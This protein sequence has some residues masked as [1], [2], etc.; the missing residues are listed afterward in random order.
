[1]NN[2]YY[3][4]APFAGL[5]S[6]AAHDFVINFMSNRSEA[7]PGG[8]LNRD[9]LKSFFAVTGEPGSFVHNRG[10]ERIPDVSIDLDIEVSSSYLHLLQNW[11]KRPSLN[12]YNIP[13][14]LA[15]VFV[16]N[17][18]YVSPY[19]EDQV[20]NHTYTNGSRKGTPELLDLVETRVRSTA[21]LASMS[22][23]SLEAS[24]TLPILLRA[25]TV[26]VSSSNWLLKAFLTPPIL[27]LELRSQFW[28]GQH[29]SSSP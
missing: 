7:N 4:S 3:F 16:N 28:A 11:Y 20:T 26:L 14:V 25:T 13:E 8:V 29:N 22:R 24:S 15:D 27:S 12:A 17:A 10:M 21:S 6:P 5:V 23:I 1:M 2:P 18:M 9:V 19:P